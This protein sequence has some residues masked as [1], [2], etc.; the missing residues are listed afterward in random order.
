[1]TENIG[2][3]LAEDALFRFIAHGLTALSSPRSSPLMTTGRLWIPGVFLQADGGGIKAEETELRE[4]W[5]RINRGTSRI[6]SN[7]PL[8]L[9]KSSNFL[10][11]GATL[12]NR[13][14][15]AAAHWL[16]INY[17]RHPVVWTDFD[18]IGVKLLASPMFTYFTL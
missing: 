12:E 2:C 4:E 13:N 6:A 9:G 14:R 16:A 7:Q 1:V 17:R 5:P 11:N 10:E 15:S 3:G 18:E 8:S